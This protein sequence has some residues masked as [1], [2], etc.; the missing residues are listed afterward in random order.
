MDKWSFRVL[1]ID[2]EAVVRRSLADILRLEGYHLQTAASGE[3]AVQ[4]LEAQPYDLVFLD[5]KMP[6]MGGL[7]VMRFIRENNLT[8]QVILLTAH[9]SLESAIEAIRLGAQDYLLKPASPEQ[10]T[11]CAAKAWQ[12]RQAQIQQADLLLQIESSL[13]ALRKGTEPNREKPMRKTG[14]PVGNGVMIDFERRLI[15]NDDLEIRL[16]PT[17][18]KMLRVFLENPERVFSHQELVLRVQGYQTTPQEAT[19]ILRPLISRL[20][21]KLSQFPGGNG[22]INNIRSTGY[23]FYETL[24]RRQ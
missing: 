22:W 10:I 24:P 16:T 18:G 14:V 2:D 23:V 9:G 19:E 21:R 13:S 11:A 15:W 12:N 8:S 7:E 20:R 6:G 17:E 1:V 3:E 5:L 4:L